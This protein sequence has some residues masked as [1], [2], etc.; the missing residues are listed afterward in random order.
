MANTD[1]L[2]EFVREAVGHGAAPESI[3]RILAEAGWPEHQVSHALSGYEKSVFGMAIPNAR[4]RY[5]PNAWF[6]TE[7]SV[8]ARE[9]FQIIEWLVV[10]VGVRYAAVR[11]HSQ[12]LGWL[13]VALSLLVTAHMISS[14]I[15]FEWWLWP[16]LDRSTL[17]KPRTIIGFVLTLTVGYVLLLLVVNVTDHLLQ[18]QL[19]S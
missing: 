7:T 6:F 14:W 18:A 15:R 13:F 19:G 1:A 11:T 5:Q 10:M 16:K 9:V 2:Q 17:K 4:S 12:A 3:R 8:F